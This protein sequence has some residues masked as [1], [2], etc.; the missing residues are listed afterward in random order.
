M[1]FGKKRGLN[2]IK[3][4]KA[5]VEK[6]TVIDKDINTITKKPSNLYWAN[7]KGAPRIKSYLP[8]SLAYKN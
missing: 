6:S 3:G 5:S 8:K 1:L 2:Q 7:R 4:G